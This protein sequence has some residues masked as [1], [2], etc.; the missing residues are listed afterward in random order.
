MGHLELVAI[1]KFAE[2]SKIDFPVLLHPKTFTDRLTNLQNEYTQKRID[3][4]VK[5][6]RV[7]FDRQADKEA[8]NAK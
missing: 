4:G 2:K 5:E 3:L 6:A 7:K 8:A 1:E